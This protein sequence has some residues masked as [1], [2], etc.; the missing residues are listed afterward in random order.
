MKC[1]CLHGIDRAPQR[2]GHAVQHRVPSQ[3]EGGGLLSKREVRHRVSESVHMR[4]LFVGA[5]E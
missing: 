5:V 3:E 4:R 2:A 1:Q